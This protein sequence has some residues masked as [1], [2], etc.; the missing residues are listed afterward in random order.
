MPLTPVGSAFRAF[1]F[2]GYGPPLDRPCPPVVPL[3]APS[4]RRRMT[5][6]RSRLQGFAPLESPLPPA[7]C[8]G[9][10]VPDALLV[11]CPSRVLPL[12]AV[13]DASNLLPSC[14]WRPARRSGPLAWISGF[15]LAGSPAGLRRDCRPFWGFPPCEV[16]HRCERFGGP[17][18]LILLEPAVP[19]PEW[20]RLSLVPATSLPEPDGNSFR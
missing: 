4:F 13:E 1:P 11:F 18:L 2:Q 3:P 17:G 6:G 5:R 19:S 16:C 10:P 8:L 15:S 12:P 9:S 7:C 14:P 20:P